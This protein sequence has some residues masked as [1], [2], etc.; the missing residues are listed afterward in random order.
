MKDRRMKE[1]KVATW[2]EADPAE[3][4][5]IAGEAKPCQD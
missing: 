2:I 4:E 1:V 5:D 3:V